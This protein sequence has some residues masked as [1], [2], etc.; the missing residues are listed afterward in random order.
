MKVRADEQAKKDKPQ[1]QQQNDSAFG[2]M[3]K[4]EQPPQQRTQPGETQKVGGV[5]EKKDTEK[6]AAETALALPLQKLDQL[7]TQIESL[8]QQDEIVRV[9]R[10]LAGSGKLPVEAYNRDF[11]TRLATGLQNATALVWD[12][13]PGILARE[14]LAEALA[15]EALANVGLVVGE[16]VAGGGL[17]LLNAL[18]DHVTFGFFP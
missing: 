3:K 14:E 17:S 1:E 9:Q 4:H 8:A 16:F 11:R 5:P 10:A 7:R 13:T 18:T 12:L 2:D 15:P 6:T